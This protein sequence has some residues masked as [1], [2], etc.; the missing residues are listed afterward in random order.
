MIEFEFKYVQV[1]SQ[2]QVHSVIAHSLGDLAAEQS[3]LGL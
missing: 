1:F 2:E 3:Y